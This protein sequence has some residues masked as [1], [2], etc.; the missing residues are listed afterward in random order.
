MPSTT[1]RLHKNTSTGRRRCHSQEYQKKP[2]SRSR[3][4]VL[5]L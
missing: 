3:C 4:S 1:I 2:Y 5:W